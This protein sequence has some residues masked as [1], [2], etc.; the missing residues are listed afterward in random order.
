[1]SAKLLADNG[2][3]TVIRPLVYVEEAEIQK[4][5]QYYS[6]PIVNCSC[7]VAGADDQKRQRMKRLIHDLTTEIPEIR[8]SMIAAIN[9]VRPRHLLDQ[10]LVNSDEKRIHLDA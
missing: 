8:N 9:N 10:N 6:F 1:M 5:C 4:Y 2:K 3:H 7:P